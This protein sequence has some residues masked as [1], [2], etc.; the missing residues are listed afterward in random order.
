MTFYKKIVGEKCYLSPF[1][2]SEETIQTL[3]KFVNEIEVA[4]PLG[5]FPCVIN[6]EGEKEFLTKPDDDTKRNSQ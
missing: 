2:T 6:Q 3:T 4:L 5:N 1:D